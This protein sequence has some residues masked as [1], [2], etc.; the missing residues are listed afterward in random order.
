[1]HA[2]H[3]RTYYLAT[4]LLPR[5]KRRHV[6]AL[7]GFARYA[8]EIVDDLAS[9]LDGPGQ[10]AALREWGGRFFAGLRG[11]PCQDPV[12][13]AVL[14]TVRAFDLEVAD[15]EKFLDSMAMDL[16]TDGY[17]TYD[18]LLG[19][20]EGSAAVIGT[21]M[22]PIL[23]SSD[24]PAAREHARQLG[25]AFQLTNFIRDVGED[26][27]RG[28]VYL[29]AEDLERFGVSRADLAAARATPQVAKLLAFEIRRA[30]AHYRAAEPGIEL[31]AP[32]SRPC[33]RV[34]FDLYGGILE[35]IERAGYQV[36]ADRVR[37]PRH[38]RLGVAGRHLLAARAAAG[39]E[40]RVRVT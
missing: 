2:R 5:W 11:A 38:R 12:L 10:A 32:S 26:L 31:L 40:R 21:M 35:E 9:T 27:E 4:L 23:E 29:P 18:D 7:Y 8:D 16:H 3:G 20:M 15:F 36:L 19:Y 13:P 34:A 25:L 17:R 30:R 37:V 39:A 1:M 24:P 22:A 33:I 14:H 6:H 28:R